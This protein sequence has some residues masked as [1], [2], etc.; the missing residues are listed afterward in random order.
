[1]VAAVLPEDRADALYHSYEGGGVKVDGPS[2]LIRKRFLDDFSVAVNYYVDM[3]SSASID[4]VTTAS[5][6]T[7]ERNQYSVGVDY[8]NVNTTLSLNIS[9]S[10]ENDYES[11]TVSF[12]I[13]QDFFSNLTTLA[14]G[15]STSSDTVMKNG[16][17]DFK[18]EVDRQN[19]RLDLTQIISKNFLMTLAVEGITDE[20]FLNNPYRSVRFVD[21]TVALGYSYQLEVY[22]NTKT[23]TAV[24]LSGKYFLPYRAA[25]S[26][27]YRN[28]S[29][30]WGVAGQSFELGYIHPFGE[31]FIFE[32]TLRSY[33]QNEADFYADLFPFQNAQN[34]LARDKELSSFTSNSVGL[35]VSYEFKMAMA[36]FEKG[37][38][39]LYYNFM[40]FK[41]DNFRD[42]R[43][44]LTPGTEP[45]YELDAGV[46]RAFVSFWF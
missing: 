29:D 4:V 26:A 37:S 7:E 9:N 14:I 19:Y 30:T 15:Y 24:A 6:Y 2:I 23:S 13:S 8:L 40:Q 12:A 11:D 10:S 1:M 34:F 42:V 31:H 28:Y 39:N 20:G 3:V 46:I 25:L 32:V 17:E 41:Y 36:G 35:G 18:E 21:S 45:L 43:V 16:Q 44:A 5:K 38:V 27:E 22:P 33:Q